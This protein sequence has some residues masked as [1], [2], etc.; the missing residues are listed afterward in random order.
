MSDLSFEKAS[1]LGSGSW[2]TA[3]AVVLGERGL[4]TT[5]Y[6]IEKE[7]LADINQNHQNSRY[8]PDV[9]LPKT[10][11]ATD[12]LKVAASAPLILLVVPS[13]VARLVIKQLQQIGVSE[14]TVFLAC[15]KG[16]ESATGLSMTQL[17]REFFPHNP[18]AALSGPTH[19]EEV[20][21]RMATATVIG[22]PDHDTA[23]RLQEVFTLP[24][25]RSYTREDME[26]IEIG[27]TVKNVFAIA[28]GIADGLGLGD[29]AKAAMVTR[30]LAEMIRLGTALGGKASTFQGLS[31]VGDLIVTCYSR[32][33]RNNS[34][35]RMLG[36][37]LT[38]EQTVDKM[39]QVAEGY[40][41]TESVYKLAKK[42]GVRTPLI[43]Q[44]YAILYENKPAGEALAELLSRDPRPEGDR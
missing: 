8:L 13:Q 21:R 29:N 17:L 16:I 4:A 1:V 36:E 7:A 11:T 34:F 6:G 43:D 39:T 26:G 25:F 28:A 15:T 35:G 42:T 41:N 38:V 27:A 31:G 32:H 9:D 40:P 24:W 18:I 2:G 30:G 44:I 3:L 5:L 22:C 14:N 20:A 37:G 12:D 33:S 19:A 23:V 10:I